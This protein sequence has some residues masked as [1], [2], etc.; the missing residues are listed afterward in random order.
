MSFFPVLLQRCS[1]S[2]YNPIVLDFASVLYFAEA[3]S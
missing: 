2:V 3:R 1:R